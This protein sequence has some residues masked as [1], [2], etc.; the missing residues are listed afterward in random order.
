MI[1][2]HSVADKTLAGLTTSDIAGY[3]DD[4]LD[5]YDNVKAVGQKT[6]REELNIIAH[7]IKIASSEWHINLSRGNP[8]VDVRKPPASIGARDRRLVLNKDKNKCEYSRLL[9]GAKKFTNMEEAI[10]L[11]VETAMRRSELAKLLWANVDLTK[12]VAHLPDAKNNEDRNIPLSTNAVNI[13]SKLKDEADEDDK[14]VLNIKEDYIT[15]SFIKI[16]KSENIKDLRWHDLRHEA[17]SRLFEKGL[18]NM[19]VASI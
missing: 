18:T 3:R 1:C 5:G 17:S 4:R 10:T 19:E 13:L 7:S 12:R 16:C 14:I 2:K 8:A 15:H 9:S 11:A 6:V